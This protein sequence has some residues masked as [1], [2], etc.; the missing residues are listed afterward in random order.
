MN[1]IPDDQLSLFSSNDLPLV[2]RLRTQAHCA[3]CSQC[4]SR[5]DAFRQDRK[6]IPVAVDSFE[7][8]RAMNWQHIESEMFA[9]IRVGLDISAIPHSSAPA[10]PIEGKI[11]SWRGAVAMAAMTVIVMTGWFLA[12]PGKQSYLQRA[13]SA[14]AQVK[15]GGFTLRGDAEG[16]GLE[17]RGVGLILRHV[18]SP[19]SRF[20]VGL[21]GSVRSSVVDQDS[22]QVT[23]SQVYVE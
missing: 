17:K 18:A 14:V 9:N 23:V 16:I 10:A 15:S 2:A 12:G 7:L 3:V 1:H 21:E 11:L 13:P 6:R 5:V 4:R 20:E 22:G 8:P 19:T